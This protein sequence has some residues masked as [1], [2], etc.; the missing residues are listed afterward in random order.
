MA[1]GS[2]II[3]VDLGT[4][5]ADKGLAKLKK[6]IQNTESTISEQEEK[7]SPLVAQAA[8]LE[9]KMKTARAEVER[10]RQAWVSGVAGA[11]AQQA[12]AQEHLGQIQGEYSKIVQQIDK[13]DENLL[14]AYEKLDRM[15]EEAGGLEQ[16]IGKAEK[17]TRK[18][19]NATKKADKHMSMFAKR[20]RGI[21]LSA[22][23]FNILS[24]GFRELTEWMGNVIKTNKE[25]RAAIARLK[26][27]LLTMV[28]PIVGA[29]IPA[30]VK[31]VDL[32]TSAVGV[33]AQM[34]ALLFGATVETSKD[35]ANAL[36]KEQQ[37]IEGVGDAAQKA[38]NQLASFDEINKLAEESAGGISDYIAPDF[39]FAS[40]KKLPKWLT[41]LTIN[42]R[43]ILFKWKNLSAKDVLEKV[44]AALTALAGAVIGFSVGGVKGAAIG[45]A[46]G[47]SVGAIIDSLLFSSD[48][49]MNKEEFLKTLCVALGTI[50]SGVLGFL[51]GGV[52]GAAI[53]VIVGASATAIISNLIFDGDGKVNKEEVL[54]LLCTALGVITGGILGFLVGGPK[55]ALIGVAVGA[56]VS[57]YISNIIFNSNGVLSREEVIKFICAALGALVGGI[58][59]F[60][61]AG[62]PTGA[63]MGVMIGATAS[64]YL[65]NLI[66]DNNGVVNQTEMLKMLC[67]ALGALVGGVIGFFVGGPMGAAIG[68][69]IGATVTITLT[70]IF[71]KGFNDL[72][73]KVP[74]FT[75]IGPDYSW[76]FK[77]SANA[78][79][80]ATGSVIPPNREF[81]AVLGD[82]KTEPE[83][84]SPLST[85]KQ[86]LME[87]M[88][89]SGGGS[90]TC[91]VNLDGREVARNTVRHV[92]DMTRSAG[93]SV[94]L[95]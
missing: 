28:Q 58:V 36:N 2:V 87:A 62:G 34:V 73:E 78:P 77:S 18:M 65:S 83:V 67:T 22:F 56:G 64:L 54:K 21:V 35:A 17:N 60:V 68:M 5:K 82:N 20:L 16:E 59:G 69:A 92:N 29:V 43:D 71:F 91:V 38:S 49:R 44:V 40:F 89:E 45:M 61:Y 50:T 46:L 85:M 55:G 39:S 25:A 24:S 66:F 90:F 70:D 30:F 75:G 47:V 31:L 42:M 76:M 84:V 74:G 41:S 7:K 12:K 52:R 37:A 11:D 8:E 79:G 53:G 86:A 26:G 6:E 32:L 95:V 93:K 94:L 72:K 51:V 80:L 3:E 33:L 19:G 63:V 27:A 23:V 15:K 13:I 4:S 1:D 57:A 14:P 48:T 10:Y 9:Q 88:Q 81:L